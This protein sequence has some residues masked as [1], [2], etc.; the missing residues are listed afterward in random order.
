MSVEQPNALRASTSSRYWRPVAIVALVS[1]LV[2]SGLFAWYVW[3]HAEEREMRR[4]ELERAVQEVLEDVERI[5][6]ELQEKLREPGGVFRRLG[7]VDQWG[8]EIR[9]GQEG[10]KRARQLIELNQHLI[11][12]NLVDQLKA[13]SEQLERHKADWILVKRLGDIVQ[14]SAAVSADPTRYQELLEKF[15]GK[16]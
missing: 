15:L 5:Q 1:L 14:E 4:Q 3:R 8:N 13:L 7:K 2:V 16:K 6:H 12:K 10:C 9:L 11:D